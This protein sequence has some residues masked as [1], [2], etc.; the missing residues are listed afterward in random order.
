MMHNGIIPT[1]QVESGKTPAEMRDKI[2]K[3]EAAMMAMPEHHIEMEVV[4]HYAPGVYMRE[5]R[6]PKGTTLTGKIHK[7]E[8]LNILSQGELTVWTEDGMKRLKASTV[9]KSNPGI[10]RVGFA[11]EDCVW[12]TVH[13]NPTEE[14]DPDKL[15]EMLIAKTFEEV[16]LLL[17]EQKQIKEGE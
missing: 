12:I 15:E 13:H 4:H 8:H 1:L 11:H 3:L 17:S 5:L 7:T 2:L 10:K 14:R 9:I 6:I 16:D